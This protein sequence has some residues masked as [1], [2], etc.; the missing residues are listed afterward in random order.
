MIIWMREKIR[1]KI[2][3]N[4]ILK[5]NIS[6]KLEQY[7]TKPFIFQLFRAFFFFQC[8]FGF[9]LKIYLFYCTDTASSG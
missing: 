1:T 2:E 4:S 6:S 3:I 5:F 7:S 8:F 9:F